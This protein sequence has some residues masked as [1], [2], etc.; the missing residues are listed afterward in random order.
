MILI[1]H[2][3]TYC[4]TCK[5]RTRHEFETAISRTYLYVCC[6]CESPEGDVRLNLFDRSTPRI[7]G[8]RGFRQRVIGLVQGGLK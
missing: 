6:R 3:I 1:D 4:P 2:I 8:Q 5:T 7:K